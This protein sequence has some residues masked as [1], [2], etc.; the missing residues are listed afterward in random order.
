MHKLFLLVEKTLQKN[1][2]ALIKQFKIGPQKITTVADLHEFL[3]LLLFF[4]LSLSLL[5]SISLSSD[6]YLFSCPSLFSSLSLFSMTMTV[7][8]G[9]L[10]SLCALGARVHGPW[11]FRCGARSTFDTT[12]QVYLRRARTT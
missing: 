4:F 7:I 8:T 2:T 5:T 9:S 3:F 1:G 10:S 6:F 12:V 11:P